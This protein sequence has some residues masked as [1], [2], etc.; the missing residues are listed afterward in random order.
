MMGKSL[1]L[2]VTH[3]WGRFFPVFTILINSFVSAITPLAIGKVG[4][5]KT[6]NKER[7]LAS[8]FDF[9]YSSYS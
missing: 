9:S 1:M 8:F 2:T 4:V 6:K 7:M 3:S 5:T